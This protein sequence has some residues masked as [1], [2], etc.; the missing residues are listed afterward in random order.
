MHKHTT[1]LLRNGHIP[2]IT[3]ENECQV[4]EWSCC[5][6]KHPYS[7]GKCPHIHS[8]VQCFVCRRIWITWC[9]YS[10]WSG[11][12]SYTR[13]KLSLHKCSHQT[14]DCCPAHSFW[15]SKEQW[16]CGV[17]KTAQHICLTE[18]NPPNLVFEIWRQGF[19]LHQ[20][21]TTYLYLS[22]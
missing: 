14:L 6:P 9:S 1:I 20:T 3:E 7:L 15:A 22:V 12:Y 10:M 17:L 21:S 8:F 2:S 16:L 19:C 4:I 5:S 13:E 11:D 18:P